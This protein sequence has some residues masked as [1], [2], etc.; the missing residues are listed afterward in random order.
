MDKEDEEGKSGREEG[1]GEGGGYKSA[2][3]ID[4]VR[5]EATWRQGGAAAT[6]PHW[7]SLQCLQCHHHYLSH[8]L[9]LPFLALALLHTSLPPTHIN[10]LQASSNNTP[11]PPPQL[12]H[13]WHHTRD[14]MFSVLSLRQVMVG[15]LS[16]T[17]CSCCW[18]GIIGWGGGVLMSGCGKGVWMLVRAGRDERYDR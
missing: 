7:H 15:A 9:Y 17:Y 1:R 12:L 8:P 18:A 16:T 13:T 2:S 4:C 11:P 6:G 3:R 14:V 10:H 5:G